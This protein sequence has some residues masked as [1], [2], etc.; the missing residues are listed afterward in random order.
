MF[1]ILYIFEENKKREGELSG[2]HQ[3]RRISNFSPS[4]SFHYFF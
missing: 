4:I 1:N 3:Y 2:I